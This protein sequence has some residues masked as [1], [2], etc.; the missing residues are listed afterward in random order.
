MILKEHNISVRLPQER[1]IDT[2]ITFVQNDKGVYKLN[3]RV[4]D[5]DTEIN[6]SQVSSATITFLKADGTVVQGDMQ[7]ATNMLMYYLGTNEIAA[8]GKLIAT[9]QL[10]GANERLTTARFV[11]NVEKDLI[12]EDAVKSTSEFAILQRL[13]KELE[14]IDVVD[15]TNQ[16][17]AHKADIVHTD[18][19]NSTVKYP[20]A[21]VT[22]QHGREIDEINSKLSVFS[23]LRTSKNFTPNDTME[24]PVLKGR[25]AYLVLMN[26]GGIV[27]Q[28]Q[29]AYIVYTAFE[30]YAGT[31]L[32]LKESSYFSVQY[33]SESGT[34]FI[35]N[36]YSANLGI[37]ISVIRIL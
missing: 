2:G 16:F 34:I 22:Y 37:D 13:K 8:P 29:G 19:V 33:I 30:S 11:F 4:F 31:V 35:K 20:S 21:A 26:Q 1:A 23:F 5:G 32:P 25:T 3:V 9:I 18:E 27:T 10:L 24:I 7:K 17:N 14:A 28:A 36:T 12:T 6:Y 15:L